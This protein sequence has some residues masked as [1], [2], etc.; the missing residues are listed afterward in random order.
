MTHVC[1][2]AHTYTQEPR[3]GSSSN[4]YSVLLYGC[5]TQTLARGQEGRIEVKGNKHRCK[6]TE[7][8]LAWLFQTSNY[9]VRL[10]RGLL[11]AVYQHQ[12]RLYWHEQNITIILSK[13]NRK[14][15]RLL[16]SYLLSRTYKLLSMLITNRI[17]TTLDSKQ[18]REQAGYHSEY[19]STTAI[20]FINQD[21]V[22]Y[23][24]LPS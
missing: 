19:S 22:Y 18:P 5:E 10:N 1:D 17:K 6:I 12:F 8:L 13:R 3:P 2:I 24:G 21:E 15:K 16:I 11:Q 20:N 23:Y 7:V 9:F 4:F 14:D